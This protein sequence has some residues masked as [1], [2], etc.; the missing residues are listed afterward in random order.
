M[1]RIHTLPSQVAFSSDEPGT[2][3]GAGRSRVEMRPDAVVVVDITP[4][5]PDQRVT[6]PVQPPPELLEVVAP[7]G[8]ARLP[9]RPA[10]SSMPPSSRLA[11]ASLALGSLEAVPYLVL[12]DAALRD[13][14]LDPQAAFVLG[15]LD[16]RMTIESV[17]DVCPLGTH[18][19]LRILGSLLS[20]GVI[21][22]RPRAP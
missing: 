8:V 18:R 6:I 10:L 7:I 13:R 3:D 11:P 15:L 19:V 22:L 17:L 1:L 14:K 21:A 9:R 12:D 5:S 20:D 16:G 2:G 4:T